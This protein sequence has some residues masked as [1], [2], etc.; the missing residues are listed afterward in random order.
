MKNSLVVAEKI[1]RSM[2]YVITI[3]SSWSDVIPARPESFPCLKK[4]SRHAGMTDT[5]KRKDIAKKLS[6][7][8]AGPQ[9]QCPIARLRV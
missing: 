7:I 1:N 8:F 4:D 9:K 6:Y 5:R 3:L 2:L